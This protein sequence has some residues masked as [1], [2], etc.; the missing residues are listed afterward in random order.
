[1]GAQGFVVLNNKRNAWCLLIILQGRNI[2][3]VFWD[4]GGELSKNP[5]WYKHDIL[6]SSHWPA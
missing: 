6:E 4:E 5:G 2:Q 1:M 3:R